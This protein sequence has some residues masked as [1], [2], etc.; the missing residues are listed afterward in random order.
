M[1][2]EIVLVEGIARQRLPQTTVGLILPTYIKTFSAHMALSI[3]QTVPTRLR[4]TPT[5]YSEGCALDAV[6]EMGG[7]RT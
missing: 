7:E 4:Q 5:T 6:A 3:D 2:V 1:N